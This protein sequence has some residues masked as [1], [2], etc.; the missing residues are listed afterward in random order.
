MAGERCELARIGRFVEREE[1]DRQPRLGPEAV[2]QRLQRLDIVGAHRNVAALVAAMA[3]EQLVI[4]V[5][6][7]AGM[8]LHHHAVL[9]AHRG[10]RSA[11]HTSELQ[12][13]MRTMD[14]GFGLEKKKQIIRT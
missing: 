6:A 12:S 13:L 11:E 5:A 4:M 10:E 2:E 7:R 3:F 8:N 1:D 14:A 9:D